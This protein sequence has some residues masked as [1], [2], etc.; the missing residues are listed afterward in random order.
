GLAQLHLDRVHAGPTQLQ[1]GRVA[2]RVLGLEREVERPAAVIAG[3]E[4][5]ERELG[6]AEHGAE[7]PA[8]DRGL[9]ARPGAHGLVRG[10]ADSEAG[11]ARRLPPDPEA[12]REVPADGDPGRL[13]GEPEAWCVRMRVGRAGP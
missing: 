8:F 5:V 13:A 12:K 3:G 1:V 10:G 7:V 9:E 2:G 11:G 6:L 4:E